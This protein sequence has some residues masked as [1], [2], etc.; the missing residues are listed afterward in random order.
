MS[1]VCSD[2]LTH[3]FK[4]Y[5]VMTEDE[6]YDALTHCR[7]VDEVVRDA[8]WTLS[9]EFLK[10]HKVNQCKH[11]KLNGHKDISVFKVSLYTHRLTLWPMMTYRTPLL[12]QKTSISTSRKQVGIQT[13][14][15]FFDVT[16]ITGNLHYFFSFYERNVCCHREDRRYLHV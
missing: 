13:N 15:E 2:E 3:K 16:S 9:T 1:P 14:H 8:P 4:G 12:D 6:R 7:Y 5:T 11:V 10:K